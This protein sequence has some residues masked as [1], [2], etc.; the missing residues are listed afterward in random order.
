MSNAMRTAV[1]WIVV[2]VLFVIAIVLFRAN[3][4]RALQA[5][6]AGKIG[7]TAHD[8]AL[9]QLDKKPAK[10][11]HYFGR[12]L[13]VNFFATWCVPCK[14]ELPLIEKR[15]VD[16]RSRGLVVLG[17]D[18]QEDA[19]LVKPFVRRMQLTYPVTIDE[20]GNATLEYHV[21]AI[22]T[23]VF[24]DAGGKVQAIHVGEMDAALMD[25]DLA[26]ILK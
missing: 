4:Q 24:I 21:S 1:G 26:K 25:T 11:S 16:L 10:L 18:E 19:A 7:T 13:W 23:S 8:V 3:L 6:P 20:S 12:P 9:V 17:V 22:P 5:G 15:Y 2:V 14:V